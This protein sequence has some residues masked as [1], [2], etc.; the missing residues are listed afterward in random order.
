MSDETG[1][2][3]GRDRGRDTTDTTDARN[4]EKNAKSTQGPDALGITDIADIASFDQEADELDEAMADAED[5]LDLETPEADAAEQRADVL[6]GDDEPLTSRPPK[7]GI[8]ADNA[9]V[10]EQRRA[11]GL[12]EEDYR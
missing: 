12:D 8:E 7:E 6:Q 4:T 3:G 9:D 10:A 2:T 1:H 5:D 11:A